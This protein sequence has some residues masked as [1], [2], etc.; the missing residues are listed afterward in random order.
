VFLGGEQFVSV[1]CSYI[2]LESATNCFV[3]SFNVFS[4]FYIT[5]FD[6]DFAE[7]IYDM[8]AVVYCGILL[9]PQPDLQNMRKNI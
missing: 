4:T 5:A 9:I 1:R 3:L 7:T 6:K 2:G 8:N